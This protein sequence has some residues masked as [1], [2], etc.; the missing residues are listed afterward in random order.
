MFEGYYA[1]M[2]AEKLSAGMGMFMAG[3]IVVILQAGMWFRKFQFK[4][5]LMNLWL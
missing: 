4:I 3:M 2:C 1:D 5:K